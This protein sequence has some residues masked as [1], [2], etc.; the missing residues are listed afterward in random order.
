MPEVY[1]CPMCGTPIDIND[2]S[3]TVI[4]P[5]CGNVLSN[6]GATLVNKER[7]GATITKG[8]KA[9]SIIRWFLLVIPGLVFVS[10][11]KKAKKYFGQLSQ[12]INA[13]ASEIE[14]YME[15]R[16]IIL[17]N[18]S[19]LIDKEMKFEKATLSNFNYQNGDL[20][21]MNRKLEEADSI[22]RDML[23][24]N[25]ELRSTKAI[26]KAIKDNDYTQREITACRSL[27]NDAVRQWNEAIFGTVAER[28]IAVE[29]HYQTRIPFTTSREIREKARSI[30]F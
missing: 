3:E 8:E 27:Y 1:R 11:K 19:A 26:E 30:L 12:K 16:V 20:N 15:Q 2:T 24:Q 4:C 28:T 29:N 13:A 21:L 5:A 6:N 10:Q 17:E 18:L 14:N 7:V 25:P 9:M 23:K 22:L